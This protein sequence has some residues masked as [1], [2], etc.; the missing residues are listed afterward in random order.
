MIRTFRVTEVHLVEIDMEET[1]MEESENLDEAIQDAMSS[2]DGVVSCE[3]LVEEV[4]AQ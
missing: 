3:Q 4:A 1:D 2:G